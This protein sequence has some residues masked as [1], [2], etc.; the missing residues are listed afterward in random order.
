IPIQISSPEQ[1]NQLYLR[2]IDPKGFVADEYLLP[3]GKQTQNEMPDLETL[4]TTISQK[5]NRIIAKGK[6]FECQVDK[7]TGQI[8]SMIRNGKKIINGGPWLMALPLTG[9]GCY[10]NHNANTPPFNE[11]CSEWNVKS[12]NANKEENDVLISVD[13]SYKEFDGNYT[14][15]INANGE[16]QVTYS[17]D[18]LQD[19]NP[20]QWG[21]VFEAPKE[22]DQLF[23]RRDGMWSV[24]PEDHISRTV[25][26]ANLY[27]KGV[28]DSIHARIQPTWAWSRDHNQLGSN[29]FRSTRRNIWY[30]GLNNQAGNQ[31]TIRSNGKQHWRSWLHN[32]RIR[33]LI[34][35]FVTAGNEMF[36]EGYYAPYRKPIKTGDTISGAVTLRIE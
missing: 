4:K 21:L 16:I 9:G 3:V 20:R 18:A 22:F 34:A 33:F 15:R 30:A 8:L 13:G 6:N 26:S 11:L 35:E 2:F 27:Y 32:D 28:P 10:P 12:V 5:D 24:Y 14:L 19:V 1:A 7:A 29:D 31:I 23:W 25:G 17:F 36:L